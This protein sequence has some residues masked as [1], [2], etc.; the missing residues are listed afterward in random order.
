CLSWSSKSRLLKRLRYYGSS[1]NIRLP[2][3]TGYATFGLNLV[4]HAIIQPAPCIRPLIAGFDVCKSSA[5]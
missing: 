1:Q 3:Y 2:F 4:G 5:Y